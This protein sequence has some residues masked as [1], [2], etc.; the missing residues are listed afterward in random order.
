[1]MFRKLIGIAQLSGLA[2]QLKISVTNC[3]KKSSNLKPEEWQRNG[4]Q[5]KDY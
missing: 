2:H 1:M 3:Q 5:I 4:N